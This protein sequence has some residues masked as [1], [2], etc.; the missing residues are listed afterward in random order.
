MGKPARSKS[1][2]K[3]AKTSK[4]DDSEVENHTRNRHVST[5][6]ISRPKSRAGKFAK[7]GFDSDYEEKT[8]KI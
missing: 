3:A 1:P 4:S 2:L 7:G 8:G 5:E 6:R